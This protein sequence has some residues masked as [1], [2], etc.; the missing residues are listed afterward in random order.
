MYSPTTNDTPKL[1]LFLGEN[2][3]PPRVALFLD[4]LHLQT[5]GVLELHFPLTVQVHM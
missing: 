1:I 3:L 5:V 4:G 2:A